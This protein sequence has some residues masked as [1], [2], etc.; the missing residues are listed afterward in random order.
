MNTCPIYRRSGGH[1]Y[2]YTIPG[3][4]GSILT[5]GIDLKKYKDLPFAWSLCGSC[6]DV[7]PVKIDIHEQLYRWRQIV[8]RAGHLPAS[9]KLGMQMGGWV[10]RSPGRF[11][12]AGALGRR[13][14]ALTPA[15]LTRT[16]TGW[17][18]R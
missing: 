3:P 18:M 8:A 4:I 14:I 13:L 16:A 1:S 15:W 5:R 7:S 11:A 6:S 2:N 17:S 9:K 10:L 12:W